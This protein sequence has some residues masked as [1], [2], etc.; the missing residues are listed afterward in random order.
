MSLF[1]SGKIIKIEG[2]RVTVEFPDGTTARAIYTVPT[3]PPIGTEITI[4][5]VRPPENMR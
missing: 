5:V 1:Q 4:Q 3:V 2:S